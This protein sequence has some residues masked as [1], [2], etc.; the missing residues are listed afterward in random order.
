MPDWLLLVTAAGGGTGIG[1]VLNALLN[2][3]GAAFTQLHQLVDQLQEDRKSDREE[4]RIYAT[5]VDTA[6]E[7]LQ[8]EREYSTELYIWGMNGAPPPPPQRRVITPP[9]L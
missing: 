1:A 6:L 4:L 8:I 7:H 9:K 3:K 2:A 5:K